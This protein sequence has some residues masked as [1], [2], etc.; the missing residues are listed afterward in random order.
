MMR[1]R[2]EH[3]RAPHHFFVS[4]KVCTQI[5]GPAPL[6]LF[7]TGTVS[8]LPDRGSAPTSLMAAES[9]SRHILIHFF[10][11]GPLPIVLLY[12]PAPQE[13]NTSSLFPAKGIRIR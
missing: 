2:H 12:L 7:F 3:A 8:D 6:R 4:G 13:R 10:R 11:I 9:H 5:E 1:G